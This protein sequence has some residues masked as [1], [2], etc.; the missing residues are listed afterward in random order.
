[1]LGSPGRALSSIVVRFYG[2]GFEE[3]RHRRSPIAKKTVTLVR[4]QN[5]DH[6]SIGKFQRIYEPEVSSFKGI[7]FKLPYTYS[8]HHHSRLRSRREVMV[9]SPLK[10]CETAPFLSPV[11][12]KN[13]ANV[14]QM[15]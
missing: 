15:N 7:K 13:D 3:G 1:M 12:T 10:L 14:K 5:M 4:K 6:G 2:S 11:P 8:T 9:I